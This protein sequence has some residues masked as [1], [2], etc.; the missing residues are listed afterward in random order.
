MTSILVPALRGEL[1]AIHLTD[2]GLRWIMVGVVAVTALVGL[3]ILSV[4]V[5]WHSAKLIKGIGE[6]LLLLPALTAFRVE[7]FSEESGISVG[8]GRRV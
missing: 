1:R 2:Y 7:V 4:G 5:E 3:D 6:V 8:S